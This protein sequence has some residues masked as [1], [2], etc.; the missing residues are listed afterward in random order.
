MKITFPHM[1]NFYIAMKSLFENL[2]F[3]VIV[4]PLPNKKTL[5][6]GTRYSPELACLPLKINVGNFLEAIEMGANT[7]VM[8]GGTGPCRFGYYGE[9]QK[10]ILEDLGYQVEFIILEPPQGDW[11]QLWRKVNQLISRVS[12]KQRFLALHLA[13]EKMK[14][15]DE[16]E[17]FLLAKRAW[18]EKQ[19]ETEKV[20]QQGII[21]IDQAKGLL[22]LKQKWE[23]IQAKMEKIKW[24]SGIRPLKV[25]IVGEIYT[26]IEPMVNLN[27][28][29]ILGDRGVEV[30]RSIY[31]SH[32]IKHNLVL[33]SLGLG[34]DKHIKEIAN[35]YLGHFVGGH[36]QESIG[37]TILYAQLGF[38]GVIHLAPFTCMPEIVAQS[39]LPK[40]SRDSNLPVLSISLD[41]HS[42]EAGLVTRI[43]AF[44]ELLERKREQGGQEENEIISRY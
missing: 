29:K 13:W 42:A 16:L 28:G 23:L 30:N 43:E 34:S 12:L 32:W 44:L 17:K 26:L 5:E 15:L 33:N 14:K 41:E 40:V 18:E 11:R 20:Y 25:G 31:L 24:K 10:E 7:V 21:M 37:E 19:G 39:I 2:G 8:A 3:E 27:L 35:P 1:G 36:G 22:E 38:D 6:L 9:V 4:P